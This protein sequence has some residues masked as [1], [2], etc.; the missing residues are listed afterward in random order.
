M[1]AKYLTHEETVAF[2]N[3]IDAMQGHETVQIVEA[4]EAQKILLETIYNQENVFKVIETKKDK[5]ALTLKPTTKR[6]RKRKPAVT[7]E[8][9][10]QQQRHY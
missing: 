5:A 7:E 4:A 10:Q 1:A 2:Q 9:R 6:E 3:D 8:K